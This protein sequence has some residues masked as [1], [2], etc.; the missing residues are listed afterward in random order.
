METGPKLVPKLVDQYP[1]RFIAGGY[2]VDPHDGMKGVRELTD[3]V[4]SYGYKAWYVSPTFSMYPHLPPN[5]PMYYPFYTRCIDLDI[6]F[7]V[8]TRTS[9]SPIHGQVAVS[10]PYHLDDVATILPELRIIG[11]A[12][13]WPWTEDMLAV[14]WRNDNIWMT[15]SHFTPARWPQSFI[16][17]MSSPKGRTR[18]AFASGGPMADYAGYLNQIKQR[19]G[20]FPKGFEE[21]Y[22]SKNIIEAL[23]IRL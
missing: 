10:H 21:N 9:I 3:A 5:H 12:F 6:A 18:T 13:P 1:K 20:T 14:V 4:K 8:L 17:F 15:T 22:F 19:F 2:D 16:D 23:K 11:R 7:F